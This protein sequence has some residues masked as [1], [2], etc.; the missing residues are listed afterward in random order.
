MTIVEALKTAIGYEKRVRDTYRAALEQTTDPTGQ[1][2]FTLMSNEENDHV[3]YLE[4]KLEELA[5]GGTISSADLT[6]KLPGRERIAEAKAAL[7]GKLEDVARETE[8]AMLT[9]ARALEIETSAFYEK[10]VAEL[11]PE[12]QAFFK[13]FVEIEKGHVLLVEAEIDYLQHKGA[14]LAIDHGELKFF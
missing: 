5:A 2:I 14:W 4:A 12:G 6:T 13:R 10:L 1:R 8:I 3:L 7:S 11:P 9:K